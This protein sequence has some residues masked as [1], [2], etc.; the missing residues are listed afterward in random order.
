VAGVARR[1]PLPRPTLRR[2]SPLTA[3]AA[4]LVPLSLFLSWFEVS[5]GEEETSYTGWYAFHRTDRALAVLALGALVTAFLPPSRRTAIARI[6]LGLLAVVV[7]VRE[8]VTPPVVDPATRLGAGAYLGLGAA[9]FVALGGVFAL[10]PIRSYARRASKRSVAAVGAPARAISAGLGWLRGEAEP[11]KGEGAPSPRL[12]RW[13]FRGVPSLS[14]AAFGL[15]RIAFGLGLIGVMTIYTDLSTRAL[16][17]D[18]QRGASVFVQPEWVRLLASRAD[19]LNAVEAITVLAL[20]CFVV[21][22][23]SRVAYTVAAAGLAITAL[24]V[25]AAEGGAHDWGLPTITIL[26]L[27]IVP[28]G[29]SGAGVDALIRRRRGRSLLATPSRRYGLAVW[30]PGLTMG[31]ALLAAVYAKLTIGGVEWI[32]EGVVKY[33]FVEDAGRAPVDWGLRLTSL[34]WVA[35]LMSLGA[36]VIEAILVLVTVSP[37][38]AVRLGFGLL[39]LSLLAGLYVFQGHFWM[40]WWVLLLAFVPWEWIHWLGR[41]LLDRRAVPGAGL[42]PPRPLS[43][44]LRLGALTLVAVFVAQQVVV[45]AEGVE[46]EPFLSNYPMYAYTW[47]SEEEFNE[48]NSKFS[49]YRF[50]RLDEAGRRVDVTR[51]IEEIGGHD[52]LVSAFEAKADEDSSDSEEA[53]E[54]RRTVGALS[55]RY[56]RRYGHPLRRVRVVH[57]RTA[58]YDFDRAAFDRQ[59]VERTAHVVDT[60]DLEVAPS[61]AARFAAPRVAGQR[62]PPKGFSERRPREGRST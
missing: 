13:L 36:M 7:V 50:E 60:A 14:P 34:E 44:G 26:C 28:W 12:G 38:P 32:T 15:F 6:L 30:I 22:L 21:G 19:L 35:I 3:A 42:G 4:T 10:S 16:A 59:V 56:E 31:V 40:T 20:V 9:V 11:R 48:D 5:S 25:I 39:G 24:V 18:D 8:V 41:R 53:A 61:T 51:R 1:E 23:A 17:P 54:L 27:L 49:N 62:R 45:S 47:D 2:A 57:E 52:T 37:R 58:G 43:G 29:S 33:H 55:S 46:Q